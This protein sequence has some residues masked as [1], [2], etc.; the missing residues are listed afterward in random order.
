MPPLSSLHRVVR[1]ARE[2]LAQPRAPL[3]AVEVGGVEDGAIGAGGSGAARADE[4]VEP[5]R[6]DT[7]VQTGD[8][9]AIL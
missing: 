1:E 8:G 2:I 5:P 4:S 3:A 7:E 6:G 9:R